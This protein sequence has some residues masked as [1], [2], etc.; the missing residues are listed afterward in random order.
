[1]RQKKSEATAFQIQFERPGMRIAI[2]AHNPQRH[3]EPFERGERRGVAN[4][5]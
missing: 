4:I 3:S 1:M 2:A 5:P